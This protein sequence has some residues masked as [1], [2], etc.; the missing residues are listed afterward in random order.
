M[1]PLQQIGDMLDKKQVRL[2]EVGTSGLCYSWPPPGEADRSGN[3]QQLRLKREG[4][5]RLLLLQ[6]AAVLSNK[7]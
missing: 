1:R 7:R 2:E 4:E 3:Q 5:G 6:L